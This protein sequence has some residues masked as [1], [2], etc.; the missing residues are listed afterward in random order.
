M[1][2]IICKNAGVEPLDEGYFERAWNHNGDGGG[3]VW[4][5]PDEDSAYIQKGF[6]K[7][8]DML[9]KLKE[10]NK[11][12]NS[13]IAHF[14]IKSVGE[15]KPENTHPFVMDKVTFAHN[16]TICGITPADGKTDSET[17][18]LMFLK[19]RSMKWIKDNQ[20]LLELALGSSKF[21]IMDNKTG[22]IFILNK[23]NGKEQDGAWF[24]NGSADKPSPIT[25][26][27]FYQYY[28]GGCNSR[29]LF[30]VDGSVK[31]RKFFGTKSFTEAFGE[32]TKEDGCWIYNSTKKPMA[33][34]PF[35]TDV[36]IS[37]NG[38]WKIN[39]KIQPSV[40]DFEKK[41]YKKREPEYK[42]IAQTQRNLQKDLAT[43]WRETFDCADEREEY[44]LNLSAQ[45]LV[46]D[47]ARRFIRNGLQLDYV[48]L[49]NFVLSNLNMV[50][51][52]GSWQRKKGD[53]FIDCVQSHIAE[54]F[55]EEYWIY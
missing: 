11:K 16:G 22:E 40:E 27:T 46:L 32:Y 31:A 43:Y 33:T 36:V 19:N 21:A 39:P 7:K 48:N 45:N 8:E 17:F 5:S 2:I 50:S 26:T 55:G 18:G 4:K 52:I 49:E 28:R 44:E 3:I 25:T 34:F 47:A 10:I 35:S 41:T 54:M 23:Q 13:F 30:D 12:E 38:M 37:R 24:S 42:L 9:A 53:M 15:V 14:R 6:M 1:C 51:W 29:Y 20:K